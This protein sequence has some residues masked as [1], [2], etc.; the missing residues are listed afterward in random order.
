M[1]HLF[2]A[3]LNLTFGIIWN[4]QLMHKAEIQGKLGPDQWGSRS[5]KSATDAVMLKRLTY[6][7][8]ALTRTNHGTFDNNAKACYCAS[9]T[10]PCQYQAVSLYLL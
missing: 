8:S 5:G 2:E 1:I 9:F 4:R 3:D 6:E 7:L 10:L